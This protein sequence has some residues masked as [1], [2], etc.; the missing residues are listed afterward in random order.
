MK[1][2]QKHVLAAFKR[3]RARAHRL[4]KT[5]LHETKTGRTAFDWPALKKL[6]DEDR[7]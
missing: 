4:H 2:S 6:R 3:I 5:R 7:P 1:K